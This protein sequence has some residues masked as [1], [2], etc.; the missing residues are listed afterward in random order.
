MTERRLISRNRC[1][2]AV[3]TKKD[4]G[5]LIPFRRHNKGLDLF[6]KAVALKEKALHNTVAALLAIDASKAVW[7]EGIPYRTRGGWWGSRKAEENPAQQHAL[8]ITAHIPD[9]KDLWML[10]RP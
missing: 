5:A 3:F 7:A 8:R 2:A 6:L 1:H 10:V 4:T 9:L